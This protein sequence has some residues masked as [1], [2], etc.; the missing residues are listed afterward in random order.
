M[1]AFGDRTN[2]IIGLTIEVYRTIDPGLLE[3][4][5]AG[6]LKDGLPLRF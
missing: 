6:C 5:Y 3:S 1:P 4:A 2:C